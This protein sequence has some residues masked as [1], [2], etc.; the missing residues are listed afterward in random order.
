MTDRWIKLY[1][2]S[3]DNFLYK[4]NRPHTR[5]EAWEDMIMYANFKD[6]SVLIG[7]EKIDVKRGQS[8]MSLQSWAEKFH[9]SKSKV[10]R[11]FN[12]LKDCN[13]IV[14][15]N[16]QKTTRLTI[17]NYEDYQGQRNDNETMMEQCR[18]DNET[19]MTYN[20]ERIESKESKE[21]N[22]LENQKPDFHPQKTI[23]KKQDFIDQII[24][25]FAQKYLENRDLE[26][27]IFKGKDRGAAGKI[28]E[29]FKKWFPDARSDLILQKMGEYF[30]IC[31]NIS[32]SWLYDRMSL[33]FII[34]QFNQINQIIKNGNKRENRKIGTTDEELAA[35]FA[36]HFATDYKSG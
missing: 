23:S 36:K 26:Y 15:E 10:N 1:Q 9:W 14:T 34:S 5:R 3:F 13:M 28:L 19:M 32:D 21:L 8:I 16:V 33:S 31:L 7:N 2:K 4:E 18:N 22:P 35:I 11:F 29:Y 17:C 6:S 20:K 25:L 30:D 27:A 12:L 24:N